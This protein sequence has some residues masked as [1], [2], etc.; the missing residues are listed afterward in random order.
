MTTLMSFFGPFV[1]TWVLTMAS[2]ALIVVLRSDKA[3]ADRRGMLSQLA[4]LLC[5]FA[6]ASMPFLC[7][8]FVFSMAE[9]AAAGGHD[10]AL[11]GIVAGAVLGFIVLGR[12][13]LF[14]KRNH[15]ANP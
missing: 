12:S 8:L 14:P 13:A 6:A 3:E 9:E 7:G 10:D 4:S 1:A 11:L 5:W 2:L 15:Q